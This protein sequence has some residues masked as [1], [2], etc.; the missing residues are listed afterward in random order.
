[1]PRVRAFVKWC[2]QNRCQAS[3]VRHNTIAHNRTRP[4]GDTR[5]TIGPPHPRPLLCRQRIY[6][7]FRFIDRRCVWQGQSLPDFAVEASKLDAWVVLKPRIPRIWRGVPQRQSTDNGTFHWLAGSPPAS[8]RSNQSQARPRIARAV[9]PAKER[10][11]RHRC[12]CHIPSC[13]RNG[14]SRVP[15]QLP[16]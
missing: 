6:V 13:Q 8:H 2:L 15:L 7:R 5:D 14:S 9:V 12:L 1:M 16:P 10:S 4:T 3:A 11:T